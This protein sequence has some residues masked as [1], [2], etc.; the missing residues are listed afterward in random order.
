MLRITGP[1]ATFEGC[2]HWPLRRYEQDPRA[3]WMAKFGQQ[4]TVAHRDLHAGLENKL[5][6][7]ASLVYKHGT[8]SGPR[9]SDIK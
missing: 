8:Y 1:P 3:Q 9:H 2:N 4:R 7:T 5:S 6:L